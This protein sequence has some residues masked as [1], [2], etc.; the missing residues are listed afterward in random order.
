ML[1]AQG[2]NFTGKIVLTRYGGIFRGLKVRSYSPD[3]RNDE[4]WSLIWPRSKE[5]KSLE[6]L[7]SSSI[8][9]LAT[10][11]TSQK[12]TAISL[13]PMAL[14]ETPRRSNVEVFNTF[15]CILVTLPRQVILRMS[16]PSGRK[17]ST[18]R[19]SP[20]YLSRGPMQRFS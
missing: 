10:T 7:G 12:I 11:D 8:P 17:V 15:H 14:Q 18:S 5:H 6:P 4:P 16:I 9:T 1:L 19:R 20:V 2:V 13:I 3:R